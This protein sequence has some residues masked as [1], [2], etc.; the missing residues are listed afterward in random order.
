MSNPTEVAQAGQE[1]RDPVVNNTSANERRRT[2]PCLVECD[3][4]PASGGCVESCMKAPVEK[5]SSERGGGWGVQTKLEYC[6]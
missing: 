1:Q 5:P 3:A 2:Q 4:C 6:R